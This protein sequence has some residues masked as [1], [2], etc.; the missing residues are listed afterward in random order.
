MVLEL[1]A[2]Y[3][4]TVENFPLTIP[5][6]PG[7]SSVNTLT[8][9]PAIG[10]TALTVTSATAGVTVSLDG[11]QFVTIDGRPGGEGGHA[12]SGGGA[13]SQLTIQNT[14]EFGAALLLANETSGN[15]LR[16]TA[17]KSSYI[18]IAFDYTW[19]DKGNDHNTIDHCDIGDDLV[20]Q[21]VGIDS[22]GS[23]SDTGT[24]ERCNSDN[25]ISN[26]NIFNFSTQPNGYS[27][28]GVRLTEGNTS[29]TITGNSF[30]Q[31][32][33][34][35]SSTS[36]TQVAAIEIAYGD[37]YTITDNYIGGSAPN[38]GGSPWSTLNTSIDSIFQGISL[39]VGNAKPSSVQ[40]NTIQ[41]ITWSG[42]IT[43]DY[44][45]PGEWCGIFAAGLVNIGT[46][47]G[48]VIGSSTGT[49][50]ISITTLGHGSAYGIACG[51]GSTSPSVAIS[52]NFIGSV[53]V[54]GSDPGFEASFTGI[55]I[56]DGSQA[57]TVSN[58]SVVNVNAGP[59][60]TGIL[61]E[62]RWANIS[63]NTIANLNNN[64]AGTSSERLVRG[65]YVPAT[66]S[67]SGSVV[68][69]TV[70]HLFT[71]NANATSTNTVSIVGITATSKNLSQNTVYSLISTETTAASV[72]GIYAGEGKISRNLVYDLQASPVNFQATLHGLHCASGGST[73]QNNM[74]SVGLKAGL[75]H[76]KAR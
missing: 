30:Y 70:H 15:T 11:A 73:T 49:G 66:S 24:T 55:L 43:S 13:A 37:N 32:H 39:N 61:S 60:L 12:G 72:T 4:S 48:N 34:T 56:T 17:C 33:S 75:T 38:A 64:Y 57:I 68:N 16:Y 5:L 53:A 6:L 29:W 54:Q 63:G 22:E 44:P 19:G 59:R 67:G 23:C 10:A 18:T 42:N 21:H 51:Y 35:I 26:C 50:S 28:K 45:W 62:G 40:G 14:S 36:F 74:I 1:Q 69:N 9:R 27:A 58:N 31:T 46:V 7:T 20:P 8:I 71:G 25:I 3:A 52:N 65:I 2:T 41:N 76:E 47:K